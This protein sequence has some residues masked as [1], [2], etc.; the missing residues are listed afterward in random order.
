[1]PH[2]IVNIDVVT[3]LWYSTWD[4][5]RVQKTSSIS[6]NFSNKEHIQ[7]KLPMSDWLKQEVLEE[8]EPLGQMQLTRK[9][10]E[11]LKMFRKTTRMQE[12]QP[13]NEPPL[14][15]NQPPPFKEHQQAPPNV[16]E[17]TLRV[18]KIEHVQEVKV[19]R[20]HLTAIGYELRLSIIVRHI[21]MAYVCSKFAEAFLFII[22]VPETGSWSVVYSIVNATVVMC[23]LILMVMECLRSTRV[24]EETTDPPGYDEITR[25]DAIGTSAVFYGPKDDIGKSKIK[26]GD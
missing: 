4:L 21:F 18:N 2:F 1:M 7:S 6:H 9:E 25:L 10:S 15:I 8:D 5:I 11:F 26:G 12:I 13:V 16:P 17:L 23:F 22:D 3:L 14:I 24:I 20:N 19:V